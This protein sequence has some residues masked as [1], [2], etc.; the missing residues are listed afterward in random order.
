MSEGY[1]DWIVDTAIAR[2]ASELRTSLEVPSSDAAAKERRSSPKDDD[3]GRRYVL[4]CRVKWGM[5]EPWAVL[6]CSVDLYS[7]YAL[8]V[9]LFSL[10]LSGKQ[11][12]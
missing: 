4:D 6:I 11:R 10:G 7:G 12:S 9:L 1:E 5:K 2:V 3:I 8:S